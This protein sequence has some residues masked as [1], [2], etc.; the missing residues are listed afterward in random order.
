MDTTAITPESQQRRRRLAEQVYR[1]VHERIASGE[2]DPARKLTE[3]GLATL[4]GVSRTP[5]REALVRLRRE[6]LLDLPAG[7]G[8]RVSL[9][10]DDLAEIMEIRLLVEPYIAARA[11]S[12]SGAQGAARLQQTLDREVHALP[13]RSVREFAM[14]NHDFRVCLFALAG[15]GR[16][17]ETASRYDSQLQF[18]RR[19]TLSGRPNRERVVAGHREIVAAVAAGD[20]QRAEAAMR[21]LLLSARD[22]AAQ[23]LQTRRR[24]RHKE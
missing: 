5:V 1:Q 22:A 24:A 13:L 23:H 11:A 4:L 7:P 21:A 10:L 2:L 19:L 14:A 6:G 18:L 3:T 17:A 9:G 15:N 16:L 20:A 12:V 8:A